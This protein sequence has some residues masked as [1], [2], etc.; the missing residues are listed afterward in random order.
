MYTHSIF[1]APSQVQ[2][3]RDFCFLSDNYKVNFTSVEIDFNHFFAAQN[4][5]HI[6]TNLTVI[7][8]LERWQRKAK[9]QERSQ[10]MLEK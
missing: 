9:M 7:S 1:F 3:V 6:T 4:I 8:C 2:V 5:S 10:N